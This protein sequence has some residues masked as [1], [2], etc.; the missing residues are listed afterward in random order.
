MKKAVAV[1][2]A[3]ALSA[4]SMVV[5]GAEEGKELPSL[6]V[7]FH[8]DYI[9][10]PLAYALY[11]NLDEEYGFKMDVSV[12]GSGAAQ[13]EALGSDSWDVGVIGSAFAVTCYTYGGYMIGDYISGSDTVVVFARNGSDI[14]NASGANEDYPEVLGSAETVKGKTVLV[15]TG[16]TQYSLLVQYLATLGLTVDDVNIVEMACADAYSAWLSGQGDIF[17]AVGPYSTRLMVSDKE[18]ST[19]VASMTTLGMSQYDVCVASK[20]AYEENYDLL[21]QFMKM[22][23]DCNDILAQDLDLSTEIYLQWEKEN[24]IEITEEE[25]RFECEIRPLL[26]TEMVKELVNGNFGEY[27]QFI[28][29]LDIASEILPSDLN[30]IME[31]QVTSNVM[32]DA[33]GI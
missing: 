29:D 18:G 12:F 11:N 1:L 9:S 19:Q 6:R 10:L 32:K 5:A 23:Y 17:P 8:T 7:S 33:V 26:T 31:S 2:L 24:G 4:G 15:E 3:A 14:A 25:A 16:G 30:K 27:E 13:N 21:V 28:V 22:I 20:Q